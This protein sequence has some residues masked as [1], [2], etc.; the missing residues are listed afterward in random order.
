MTYLYY[1]G[2]DYAFASEQPVLELLGSIFLRKLK[3]C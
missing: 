1:E 2:V 3:L